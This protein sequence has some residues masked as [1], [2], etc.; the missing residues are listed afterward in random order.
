MTDLSDL[1]HA[2]DPKRAGELLDQ[3]GW[4]RKGGGPRQNTPGTRRGRYRCSLPGLAGFAAG[5]REGSDASHHWRVAIIPCRLQSFG[6][7]GGPS[8]MYGT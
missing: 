1:A 5:R 6:T 8:G 3:A 7:G 4:T 2:F